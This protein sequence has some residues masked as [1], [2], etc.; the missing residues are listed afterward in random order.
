MNLPDWRKIGFI[1]RVLQ[2]ANAACT[3]A[4]Q[5]SI[6]TQTPTIEIRYA[7]SGI[8]G[9]YSPVTARIL[10]AQ[11][12]FAQSFRLLLAGGIFSCA[13]LRNIRQRFLHLID[14]NQA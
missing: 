8:P 12:L 14:Q 6:S 4:D 10:R 3:M 1:S 11:F 7:S 5:P 9:G 2:A 13:T